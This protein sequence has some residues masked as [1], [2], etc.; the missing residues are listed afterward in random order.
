MAACIIRP[1]PCA[2]A[3]AS[4]GR[5]MLYA[6]CASHGVPHRK[7]GK[8]IVATERARTGQD[9]RHPSAGPGERRRG[10]GDCSAATQARALE[11]NLSCTRRVL[12]PETGIIDSHALHAGAAGR[13]GR[14]RRR[15]RLRHAGRAHDPRRQR[16]G[17]CIFGGA[18]PAPLVVDAV[19][20]SAGLGAQALRA[21]PRAIRPSACRGSCW[22][23][24]II[25]A[26]SASRPSRT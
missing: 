5:R 2:P 11:P 22:P 4:R 25:S 7:C 9:R 12:S 8:L 18:E 14:S 1:A 23:R 26:A 15:H 19:V 16:A 3:T 24:A 20:N 13:S 17:T 6:F 21:R 10:P